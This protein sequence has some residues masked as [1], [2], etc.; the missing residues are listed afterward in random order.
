[1]QDNLKIQNSG[2]YKCSLQDQEKVFHLI[3]Q[4]NSFFLEIFHLKP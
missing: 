4:G 1:M 2:Y 3:V